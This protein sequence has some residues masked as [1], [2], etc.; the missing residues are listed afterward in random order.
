MTWS[1]GFSRIE[2]PTGSITWAALLHLP[3]SHPDRSSSVGIDRDVTTF[4]ACDFPSTVVQGLSANMYKW[5]WRKIETIWIFQERGIK[6]GIVVDCTGNPRNQSAYHFYT[7]GEMAL[8][9]HIVCTLYKKHLRSSKLA[10]V[11]SSSVGRSS[12]WDFEALRKFALYLPFSIAIIIISHSSVKTDPNSENLH[13]G[14]NTDVRR[15][16]SSFTPNSTRRLRHL[17]LKLLPN[18]L[19]LYISCNTLQ[20]WPSFSH[21][22]TIAR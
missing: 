18:P 4:W 12:S 9:Q 11:P 6:S 22:T 17:L 20:K 8:K 15:K 7:L 5:E 16:R 14:E 1:S 3:T 10:F 2:H 13:Q 21:A 19:M